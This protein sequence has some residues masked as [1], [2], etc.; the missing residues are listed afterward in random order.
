MS[1]TKNTKMVCPFWLQKHALWLLD[2]S[3][4]EYDHDNYDK[5][6]DHEGHNKNNKKDQE[7]MASTS[8]VSF[9]TAMTIPEEVESDELSL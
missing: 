3:D 2:D 8:Q 9:Y 4:D 7:H 1:A 5:A 6:N